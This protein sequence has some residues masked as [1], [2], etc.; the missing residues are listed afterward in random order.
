MRAFSLGFLGALCVLA[1]VAAFLPL[2]YVLRR[3]WLYPRMAVQMGSVAIAFIA[4]IWLAE[5]AFRIAPF[6]M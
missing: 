4:A 2:A 5:R 3:W 6:W 1:I